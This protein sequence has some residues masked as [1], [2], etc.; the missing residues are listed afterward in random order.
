[1]PIPLPSAAFSMAISRS[2]ALPPWSLPGLRLDS[3][4]VFVHGNPLIE[5]RK[6]RRRSL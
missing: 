4:A 1:M 2:R 3:S 6:I 5:A